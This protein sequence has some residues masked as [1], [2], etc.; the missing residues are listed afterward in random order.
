MKPI[1]F[2]LLICGLTLHGKVKLE[3]IPRLDTT[4]ALKI[5]GACHRESL[6]QKVNVAIVVVGM[7]GRILASSKS[8]K[9]DPGL[10][11]FAKYKAQTSCFKGVAT[12]E[13]PARN[14]QALEI[15]DIGSLKVIRGVQGGIP[16][17]YQGH[18]P[19]C[20]SVGAI[21]VS[22]AMPETDKTI[23]LK[24][25]EGFKEFESRK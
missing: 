4:T 17:Y 19:P 8:E 25:I 18:L 22:G 12:E 7:D 2:I 3:E 9:M 6:V 21:G 20:G 10:Y 1:F 5:L 16:L 15:M 24:G 13:L 14:G 11:D 23:A